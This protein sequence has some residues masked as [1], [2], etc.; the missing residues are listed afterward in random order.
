MS[1]LEVQDPIK[2]KHRAMWALGNY[3]AVATEVIPELGRVV[4]SAAGIAAGDRVLDVA[5]GSGN[6]S[7]PAA[8]AGA[9]VV[10]SDLTPELLETGRQRAAEQGLDIE[11]VEAD[12][13]R[14]P[15]EDRHFDA[16]ISSVGVMF[17]PFHQ[18]VADELVRVTRAGG[19]IAIA[20]WTPEGF[21]GQMFTVMK[22][23]AAPPP[24]G[25]Q[26]GPLWGAQGHVRELFGPRVSDLQAQRQALDVGV[27]GSAEEFRDYFKKHYGPTIAVYRNIADDPDRTAAL[28][29]D[30]VEL[31]RRFGADDG[32][33]QW[34]YLL[35][36]ARR[37]A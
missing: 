16:V 34:E 22:P 12:A 36:T 13:E 32:T 24:A 27:F 29:R 5:A 35:V 21:I 31:A 17:A 8:A 23:Y 33:M 20:N 11:W 18:P 30:L 2:R 19:T 28:D 4:A 37:S 3:D 7:L 26:P 14:L 9:R 1:Q 25:A 15:F 10:A 6:A